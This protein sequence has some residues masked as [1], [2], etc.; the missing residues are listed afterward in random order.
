MLLI[1]LAS[2]RS[3]RIEMDLIETGKHSARRTG[4]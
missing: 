3:P 2:V 4:P 1:E